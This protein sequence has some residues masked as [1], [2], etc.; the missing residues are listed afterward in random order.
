MVDSDIHSANLTDIV[1]GGSGPPEVGD[2]AEDFIEASKLHRDAMGWDAPGVTMLEQTP[3]MHP[4]IARAY[5]GYQSRKSLRLPEAT[6]LETSLSEALLARRSAPQLSGE[7]VSLEEMATVLRLSWEPVDETGPGF[8]TQ[9]RRPS[10][11]AGALNPLD[12]WTVVTDVP[13][14]D[15]GLY[16]VRMP[17]TGQAE[18]VWISP[19]DLDALGEAS[20]QPDIVAAAGFTVVISAMPWRSRFKYGQRALRFALMESGHLAQDLQLVGAALGL[21]SRPL[22]GFCDDEVSSLLGFDGVDEVPLYLLP[23]GGRGEV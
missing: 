15:P 3:E 2:P 11:S 23:F 8:G 13:G 20:L 7:P 1:Y 6:V 10:P 9:P 19:V 22:G 16:Y 4:V 12:V 17:E 18:L 21:A 5:R 14:V